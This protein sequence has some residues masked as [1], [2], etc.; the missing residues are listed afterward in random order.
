MVLIIKH[1]LILLKF[2]ESAKFP[3]EMHTYPVGVK[4]KLA[5]IMIHYLYLKLI[6]TTQMILITLFNKIPVHFQTIIIHHLVFQIS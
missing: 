2:D 4:E 5:L 6:Q 3:C 1:V